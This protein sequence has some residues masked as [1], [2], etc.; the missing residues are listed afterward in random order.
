MYIKEI[1]A[2]MGLPVDCRRQ[3]QYPFIDVDK[4]K[5]AGSDDKPT[6]LECWLTVAEID[7]KFLAG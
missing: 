3:E 1:S 6:W 4:K 2:T 7:R 5:E